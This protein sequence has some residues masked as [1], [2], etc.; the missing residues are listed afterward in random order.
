MNFLHL[1]YGKGTLTVPVGDVPADWRVFSMSQGEPGLE[2]P[3]QAFRAACRHPI[4][5]APLKEIVRPDQRVLVVTSD[6]TR[7]VPNHLLVPWLLEELPCPRENVTVLLG[8]GSHRPNTPEEIRQMFGEKIASS[9]RIVNHDA[10]SE[11]ENERV[12]ELRS[13]GPVW[14]DRRYLEADV[15]VVLGFIEPHF[16]AGYSGGA[17]GIVPGIAG[18]ETILHVHRYELI[19]HPRSTWRAMD[20]NPLQQEIQ[21]AVEWCPPNF[22]INV[23]LNPAKE[24]TGVFAGDYR[25]AH[26]AGWHWLEQRTTVRVRERFPV[27]V[28]SN[29]GFPL[30]QNLYQTVKG[31]SAA[32]QIAEPGGT[33]LIASECSD[34]IPDSG[35]FAQLMHVGETPQDVLSWIRSQPETQLDQ[36]EAQILARLLIDFD[37]RLY[38]S[39]PEEQVR[40]C[41]LRPIRN[42]A[43][44]LRTVVSRFGTGVPVAVLPEG[45]QFIPMVAPGE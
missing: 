15:T 32:A 41:K 1:P 11:S 19:D 36:W 21:E 33:I 3:R 38:S 45:P 40:A 18:I 7:P 2:D 37:V 29:S 6:G 10:Y 14:I 16:F 12:G 9:L 5:A 34:G 17:K 28:T 25:A 20:D 22:L 43:E 13:G 31:I 27:V 30:D 42:F 23:T 8:T 26:R 44:E 39:L 35:A 24:I 4:D